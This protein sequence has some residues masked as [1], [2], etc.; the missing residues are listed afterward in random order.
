VDVGWSAGGY[1]GNQGVV[2]SPDWWVGLFVC[3]Q[4]EVITVSGVL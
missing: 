2:L 1:R 4:V 3:A